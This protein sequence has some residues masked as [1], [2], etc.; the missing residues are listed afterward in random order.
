MYL[1]SGP[2]L[3][4]RPRR[5]SFSPPGTPEKDMTTQII[6]A[7][8]NILFLLAQKVY[9]VEFLLVFNYHACVLGRLSSSVSKQ[10]FKRV[11]N[12]ALINVE[13]KRN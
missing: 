4:N 6:I 9:W 3:E 10:T 5:A 1:F 2:C 13:N 8:A 7:A 11:F 12:Y